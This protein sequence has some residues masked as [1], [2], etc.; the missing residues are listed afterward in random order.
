MS[1]LYADRIA[2]NDPESPDDP[3]VAMWSPIF[4]R[5]YVELG[6]CQAH[7]YRTSVLARIIAP[8]P[9]PSVFSSAS[10]LY[11]LA[12]IPSLKMNA[13]QKWYDN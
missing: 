6:Y 7:I 4:P 11:P 5:I 3:G 2:A 13:R 12:P 10:P 8:A 1:P 9:P